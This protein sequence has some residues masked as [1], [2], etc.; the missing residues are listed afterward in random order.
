MAGVLAEAGYVIARGAED[1]DLLILNTCTV[2]DRTFLE[3]RKRLARLRSPNGA[4]P[5]PLIVAGCIPK[6]YQRS[7]LLSGVS[8]LGP[9]TIDRAA[10]VVRETLRGRIVHDLDREG[11]SSRPALPTLR[12]NPIVEILPIAAGCRSACTFCQTRLA[13]GRLQSFS[14]AEILA[15]ARRALES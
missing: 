11:N 14:P 8:T 2:K 4:P 1:A 6:A 15:Q 13:R 9:D 7:D 3:F 12:R 5:K 10:E